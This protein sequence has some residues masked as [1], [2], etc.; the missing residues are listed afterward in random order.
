MASTDG[1]TPDPHL[2]IQTPKPFGL[3]DRTWPDGADAEFNMR[4]AFVQHVSQQT[5]EA[6]SAGVKYADPDLFRAC[7]AAVQTTVP[8]ESPLRANSSQWHAIVQA[9]QNARHGSARGN[10]GFASF[11][12]ERLAAAPSAAA[13]PFVAG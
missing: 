3:K 1:P 5:T 4:V 7:S 10:S 8:Q 12:R 13:A 2:E 11:R 6:C 9:A